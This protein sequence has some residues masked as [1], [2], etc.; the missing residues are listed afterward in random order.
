MKWSGDE[1]TKVKF[2]KVSGRFMGDIR[3]KN[4]RQELLFDL[5]QDQNT[6][7]IACFGRFETGKDFC[8]LA[9][10]VNLIESNKIEK[11]VFVRNNIELADSEPI[12]FRKGDLF[13]KLIEFAMPLADHL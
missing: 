2:R 10:A 11:I 13:H 1:Y 7:V 3:P 12:G 9:H 5:L 4:H 6:T 8:M